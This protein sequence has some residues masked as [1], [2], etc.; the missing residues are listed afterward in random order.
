MRPLPLRWRISLLVTL[1]LVCVITT[2]SAV[3]YVEL[4]ESLVRNADR[5]LQ[6]IANA[7]LTALSESG[8]P[9]EVEER[10]RSITRSTVR[11]GATYY[12]ILGGGNNDRPRRQ[13]R[14]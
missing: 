8:S 6:A 14:A 3:A 10:V 1:V 9:Q 2:V 4:H 5:T 11:G 12:R 7:M 13:R